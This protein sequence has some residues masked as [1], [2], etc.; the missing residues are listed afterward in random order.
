MV[1]ALHAAD[2]AG[3]N[4]PE[5]AWRGAQR[6]FKR[7]TDSRGDAGYE[8]PGG[9]S[10]FLRENE[11]KYDPCAAMTGASVL[12][13]ITLGERRSLDAI[14]HGA[15]ILFEA[16]PSWEAR[17]VNFY[18]WYLGTQ[19]MFQVGGRRWLDWNK[20]LQ[21]ALLPRQLRDGCHD[22]SWPPVGEW[23]IAGGRVYATALNALTLETYYRYPRR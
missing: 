16:R 6:W 3:L 19:A 11:G 18:H 4:V 2:L 23:C 13:R 5:Q 1:Q 9:G 21:A 20:S 14:R 8:T 7:A 10:S 22:G 15:R 12:S 17:S